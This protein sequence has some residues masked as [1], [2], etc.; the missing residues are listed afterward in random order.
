VIED[1]LREGFRYSFFQAVRMLQQS[2]RGA[3]PV[4]YQGPVEKEAVRFRPVLDLAFAPSDLA[5]VS[6][7]GGSSEPPRYE[8]AT[9]FLSVYGSVSPLPTY[10]TE[11]LMAR[12]EES[13]EREFLDLFHH[14]ALSLFYRAWEKYRYAVG[15]DPDGADYLSS[16]LLCL[17]GLDRLPPD[18]RVG[19]VRL[20]AFAGLLTQI[21]RSAASLEALLSDYLEG[22]PVGVV[23]WVG[24]WVEV[25]GD[26]LNR[27]GLENTSL[28]RDLTVGGRVH[29]RSSTF[30]VALGPVG[31][32]EFMT[33]LPSGDRMPEVRELVDLVNGDGLDWEVELSLRED[34]VPGLELSAPAARLGWSTWLGR[35][36]G[37]DTRVRFLVKGW[38][39]GGS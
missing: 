23:P 3:A 29:D 14:R 5:G 26:Q 9:T 22:V 17:L 6:R 20:L 35:R 10:F 2:A 37:M 4:G 12:D 31:L 11:E 8:V 33:F 7:A 19:K 38:L 16:R 30:R 15:F 13:L 34:E 36:G 21:P 32:Q 24:R 28:G 27:L 18:H 39:H 25:P 1:L